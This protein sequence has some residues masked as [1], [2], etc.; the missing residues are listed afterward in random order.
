M[1]GFISLAVLVI[2]LLDIFVFKWS[3][4]K[5]T[6]KQVLYSFVLSGLWCALLVDDIATAGGKYHWAMV[7]L[8]T[9][10]LGMNIVDLF[11]GFSKLQK[12]NN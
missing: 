4:P 8:D 1:I 9:V 2:L 6:K 7:L 11:V 10:C 12:T 3:Y 5:G